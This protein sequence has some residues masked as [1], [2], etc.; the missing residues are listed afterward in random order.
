MQLDIHPKLQIQKLTVGREQSPLVVIDN[1][2]ANPEALI[3]AASQKTYTLSTKYY[4]GIRAKAPLQYKQLLLQLIKRELFDF[5]ELKTTLMDINTCE[6]SLVTKS[7]DELAMMQRI[8]HIDWVSAGLASVHYLFKNNL[9]GTAFY[10][11]R[12][13]G[14]EFVDQSRR[15]E[16]FECLQ[17]QLEGPDVPQPGYIDGDSALF[18]RIDEQQSVFNR[19]LIYRGNSLHSGAI[20]KHFLPDPNPRTGR[21]TINSFIEIK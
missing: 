8:P 11:H 12:K 3:T 21:L 5:F 2:I 10:R 9:G 7:P 19:I 4:P 16:Y 20:D 17:Q 1:F 15:Q 13:T 6:F 18:E 14:F